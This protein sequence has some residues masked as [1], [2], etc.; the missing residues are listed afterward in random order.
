MKSKLLKYGKLLIVFLS[1]GVFWISCEDQSK[2]SKVVQCLSLETDFKYM[3]PDRIVETQKKCGIR[4]GGDYWNEP[5]D[6][7]FFKTGVMAASFQLLFFIIYILWFFK[8]LAGEI[9]EK[10]RKGKDL[11]P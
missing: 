6:V 10:L 5:E 8:N 2:V 4:V 7:V 9:L 1:L 3:E 11:Y